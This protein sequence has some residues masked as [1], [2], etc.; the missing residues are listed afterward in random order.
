MTI[1]MKEKINAFVRQRI[2]DE[3]VLTDEDN[4]FELGLVNSLF[5]LQLVMF[6]ENEFSIQVNNEDLDIANF[7]SLKN[8]YAL[9]S[10]NFY[11]FEGA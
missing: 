3:I 8:L 1:E 2:G 4:I 10:E 5:A 9:Q 7:S 6:L 11:P